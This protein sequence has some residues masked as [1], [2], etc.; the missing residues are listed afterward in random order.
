[1]RNQWARRCRVQELQLPALGVFGVLAIGLVRLLLLR[2]GIF[3]VILIVVI[4]VVV[5]G[6][7]SVVILVGVG[8]LEPSWGARQLELARGQVAD[9][10][11][12]AGVYIRPVYMAIG[13]LDGSG[14]IN[15]SRDMGSER[16]AGSRW[17]IGGIG[18]LDRVICFGGLGCIGGIG[19]VG[20]ISRASG[21]R[22][23]DSLGGAGSSKSSVL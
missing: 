18:R 21:I 17:R 15:N 7:P 13:A 10:A 12:A 22:I 19:G 14:C 1:V 8:E 3:V 4:V 11:G 20:G 2:L 5:G 9:A 23:G 16:G 6:R